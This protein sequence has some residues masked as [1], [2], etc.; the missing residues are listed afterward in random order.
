FPFDNKT[1][2]Q[3]KE[4]IELAKKA[5]YPPLYRNIESSH[6]D[7]YEDL[8]LLY[9]IYH[10]DRKMKARAEYINNAIIQLFD[11]PMSTTADKMK[12]TLDGITNKYELLEYCNE[13]IRKQSDS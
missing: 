9:S 12:V 7:R 3:S 2:D 13:F 8:Q 6:S 10:D 4:Y 1:L 11:N 5:A